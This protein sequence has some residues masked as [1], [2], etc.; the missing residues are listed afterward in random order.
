MPKVRRSV[1]VAT[2]SDSSV[3]FTTPMQPGLDYVFVANTDCWVKVTTTGGAAV[4]DTADNFFVLS[5]TEVPL[6][7]PDNSGTT[8]NSFVHAIRNTANG[9]GCLIIVE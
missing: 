3:K 7:S 4:A 8:T 9:T 6:R 5:G 1:Q 2:I